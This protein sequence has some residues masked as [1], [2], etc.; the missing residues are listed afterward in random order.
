[1]LSDETKLLIRK[2]LSLEKR[3]QQLA[4]SIRSHATV[5]CSAELKTRLKGAMLFC[6]MRPE[7]K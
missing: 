5:H 7:H 4:N 3:C 2:S 1:M 6:K